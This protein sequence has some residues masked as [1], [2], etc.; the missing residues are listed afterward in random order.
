MARM[1]ATLLVVAA[2][3][4]AAH[5]IAPV[6]K[7]HA[8]LA[9]GL[10]REQGRA[11][12]HKFVVQG[13]QRHGIS[14]QDAEQM[15]DEYTTRTSE[16]GASNDGDGSKED[17][18][19]VATADESKTDESKMLNDMKTPG[20]RAERKEVEQE[21]NDDA[22]AEHE[23]Q[24]EGKTEEE[25]T[26]EEDKKLAEKVA[27]EDE[28]KP[29]STL[30]PEEKK[31]DTENE[32]TKGDD[33]ATL[34]KKADNKIKYIRKLEKEKEGLVKHV[35]KELVVDDGTNKT[36]ASAQAPPTEEKGDKQEA[37]MFGD[38]DAPKKAGER[39]PDADADTEMEKAK[40]DSDNSEKAVADKEA[41]DEKEV[42]NAVVD[43]VDAEASK[44]PTA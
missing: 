11:V 39:P 28:V 17:M 6:D 9:T 34:R 10:S 19:K 3:L 14:E 44:K 16:L 22:V 18:D 37:K 26:E 13:L 38:K 41:T 43:E 30:T 35:E 42:A 1:Q 4:V 12:Y 32:P 8:T 31:E 20:S 21:A 33:T 5:A 29:L 23:A 15:F 36:D 24:K 27:T 25:K 2:L 40:I 7:D